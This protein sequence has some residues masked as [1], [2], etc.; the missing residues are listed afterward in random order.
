[1]CYILCNLVDA[2]QRVHSM[3]TVGGALFRGRLYPSIRIKNAFSHS[4]MQNRLYYFLH[5]KCTCDEVV[6]V[7]CSAVT[8]L[9]VL[10]L[11]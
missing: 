8:L 11:K 2:L 3:Y 5:Y 4:S 1:M 10:H 6:I 9:S 7:V